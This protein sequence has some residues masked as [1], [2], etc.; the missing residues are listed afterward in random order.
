MSDGDVERIMK[1]AFC[2]EEEAR[3]ALAKTNDVI[4]AVDILLVV[5]PTLGAPKL[6]VITEEQKH[7]K[8]IRVDMEV[9]DR[10]NEI[11]LKK[12]DQSDSSSQELLHTHAPSQE[13]MLLHSDCTQN[14]HLPTLEEEEQ[15]QETACQ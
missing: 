10:A 15:T 4:D 8:Q 11:V 9:I 3:Q 7:L 14:S 5:P 13:E 1:L 2:T 12:S 6:K